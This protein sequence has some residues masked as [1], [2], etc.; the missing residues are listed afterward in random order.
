MGAF[1]Q[2][3]FGSFSPLATELLALKAGLWFAFEM[4]ILPLVVEVDSTEVA[5]LVN[6]LNQSWGE[7]GF[8]IEEIK[9]LMKRCCITEVVF[10][11]RECNKVAHSLAKFILNENENLYCIEYGPEWLIESIKIDSVGCNFSPV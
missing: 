7:E 9:S 10:Q 3:I 1:A 4:R 5:R 8:L 6:T 11:P 2:P